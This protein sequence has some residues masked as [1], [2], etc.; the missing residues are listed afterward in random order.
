MYAKY[1]QIF[2]EMGEIY[3]T[4]PLNDS[5]QV[6]VAILGTGRC[7]QDISDLYDAQVSPLFSLSVSLSLSLSLLISVPSNSIMPVNCVL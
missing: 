4:G 2:K 1:S 5:K 7:Y 3:D 6:N